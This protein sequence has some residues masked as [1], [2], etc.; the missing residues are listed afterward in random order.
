MPVRNL[1]Q[2]KIEY[3]SKY[4]KLRTNMTP[5]QKAQL[6]KALTENFVSTS[7]YKSADVLLAFVSKDIEVNTTEIIKRAFEDGKKVAVPKCRTEETLMDFYY[8][9]SF[10]DLVKGAYNIMEPD[11]E[12]CE[13]LTDFSQGLCMVPGLVFDRD[14]YR[15]GFGK[16]Y[17]DRFLGDFKGVS[18]GV[19]YSRCTENQLPRGYYDKPVDLV[20]TEKYT[21]HTGNV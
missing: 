21:V 8:I 17:Y 14:G 18:V 15:L 1:K 16:G 11:E 13:K 12:K 7:E 5:D 2:K 19:C 10:D 4:K 20:V 6:D 3:R 9:K